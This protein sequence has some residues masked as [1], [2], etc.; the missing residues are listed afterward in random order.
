MCSQL[1]ISQAGILPAPTF[2]KMVHQPR[3]AGTFLAGTS[4]SGTIRPGTLFIPNVNRLHLPRAVGISRLTGLA[5]TLPPVTFRPTLARRFRR[6]HL[7]R[8]AAA[9][10]Q[11]AGPGLNEWSTLSLTGAGSGKMRK[12][13]S[14]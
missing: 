4:R 14:C 6:F 9:A 13:F 7:P 3:A 1:V 10:R 5:I 8:T 12:N 2:Q 11:A